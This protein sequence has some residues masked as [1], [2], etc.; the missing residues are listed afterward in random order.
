MIYKPTQNIAKRDMSKK[1]VF[2][3]GSIE[4]GK[5]KDWQ[6]DM[7]EF[8]TSLGYGVF[9]PRRDDWN[10][11]W[12]Q[13]FTNPQFF[14]QVIWELNALDN[15]DLILFYI[16]PATVSPITLYEF[17]RYS[18]SGKVTM[19][20]PDGFFRKGNIDIAC[21]KDNIPLFDTLEDY[22]RYFQYIYDTKRESIQN[23]NH[24]RP[25]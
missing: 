18:T 3:G 6:K 16:D 25:V 23:K 12:K 7:T 14:Q 13:D 2:L 1:Y 24:N 20:C 11:D 9:N 8:Y 21:F 19:V 15:A 10:A 4:N 22:K 5:A 17:G